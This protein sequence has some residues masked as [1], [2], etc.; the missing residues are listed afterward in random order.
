MKKTL[1]NK[2]ILVISGGILAVLLLIFIIIYSVY[3]VLHPRKIEPGAEVAKLPSIER[4]S[5]G[6]LYGFDYSGETDA[7]IACM[8]DSNVSDNVFVTFFG[9]ESITVTR[10]MPSVTVLGRRMEEIFEDISDESFPRY[11]ILGIDPYAALLQSCSNSDLYRKQI[12][13]IRDIAVS[14]PAC[15]ILI[16]LPDD[17]A[18]KWASYDD[19]KAKQARNSYIIT[20]RELS[21]LDNIRIL[22]NSTEDWVL[23]SDCIREGGPFSPILYNIDSHMLA[24]NIDPN[25]AEHVLTIDNVNMIMDETI[26]RAR[27]YEEIRS[28]YADLSGKDVYFIGDSIFGNFRDGTAVSSFFGDMTGAQVYNLGEGGMSAAATA[29]SSSDIGSAFNYLLGKE[30]PETFSA[31][32]YGFNSYYAYWNAAKRLQE[33]GG[34][35]SVFIV[36]FG[37]NDYFTGITENEFRDAMNRIITGLK[38]TYPKGEILILSP[39]FIRLY[40]DGTMLPAESGSTL[41]AY[42]DITIEVA[43]ANNCKLLSLTEDFGFM[44]EDTASYLLPDLVHYNENGRYLLAQGLARFFKK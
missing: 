5:R 37:L 6:D 30:K 18:A 12:A 16:T 19:T 32:C 36:E 27:K 39:G 11:I 1:Q 22:Y 29:N 2:R 34:E 42:R 43:S 15:R 25:S 14:H 28:T 23:Y 26:E 24:N 44:Q 9:Y 17:S 35:N 40:N 21:G 8:Y 31:R 33:T 10:R 7:F 20:V 3:R 4:I 41:Q 13:F 38:S